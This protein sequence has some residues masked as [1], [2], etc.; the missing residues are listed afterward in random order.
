MPD[1]D[2]D[3]DHGADAAQRVDRAALGALGALEASRGSARDV[4][5]AAAKR[6][7]PDDF[8]RIAFNALVTPAL[9]DRLEQ[10]SGS[11]RESAAVR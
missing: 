8:D 2:R 11:V 5:L 9:Y 4:C 7:F 1:E 3:A 10:L 6:V